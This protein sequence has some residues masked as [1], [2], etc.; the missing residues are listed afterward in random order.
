MNKKNKIKT[1]I[2]FKKGKRNYMEDRI[3]IHKR[4]RIYLSGVFDGH[5]GKE[6]SEY[7]KKM[8]F[9]DFVKNVKFYPI[10][11]A[12]LK[13]NQVLNNKILKKKWSS[14]STGNILVINKVTNTFFMS[15]TGDSRGF[16]VYKNGKIK[17]LS[18]DHK[19]N[20]PKE[21]KRIIK[22]GGFVKDGRVDGILAVARAFGDKEI[23]NHLTV[24]P[25]IS[26]GSIKN[27]S[28][29][30]QASDGIFDVLTNQRIKSLIDIYFKKGLKIDAI[31]KKITSEAIKIGSMDNVSVIITMM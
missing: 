2:D 15:N 19:P 10:K 3:I 17:Q 20:S 7:L 27:I 14:G 29:F 12:L 6:C 21:R 1:S 4:P 25:D 11:K 28:Y 9:K 26:S 31:V 23:A 22:Q 13:T 24:I 8:F 5:G 16:A 18:I 30:F